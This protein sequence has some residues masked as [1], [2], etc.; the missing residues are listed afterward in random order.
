MLAALS[1]KHVA[2]RW[3]GFGTFSCR[4]PHASAALIVLVGLYTGWLGGTAH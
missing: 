4:A 2:G 3:L 1:V